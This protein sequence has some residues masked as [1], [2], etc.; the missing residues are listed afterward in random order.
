M[1]LIKNMKGKN[2]MVTPETTG[3]TATATEGM[4]G[5]V[6]DEGVEGVSGVG[7][8]IEGVEEIVEKGEPVH[9]SAHVEGGVASVRGEL[10]VRN[11]TFAEMLQG[12]ISKFTNAI[13]E[14]KASDMSVDNAKDNVNALHNQFIDAQ[15]TKRMA[16]ENRVVVENRTLSAR[17]DLVGVLNSWTP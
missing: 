16:M 2:K 4:S 14:L 12:A 5:T 10:T 6:G 8:V 7:D 13:G 11:H 1:V 3:S 9:L 15:A 17:D